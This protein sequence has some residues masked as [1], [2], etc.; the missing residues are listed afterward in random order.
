VLDHDPGAKVAF[1]GE[2]QMAAQPRG[3]SPPICPEQYLKRGRLLRD[4]L[5]QIEG[6]RRPEP[7]LRN[8]VSPGLIDV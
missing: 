8:L 6:C 3:G 7:T 1:G 5:A 4:G 2:R